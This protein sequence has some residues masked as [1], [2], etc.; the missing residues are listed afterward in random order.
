MAITNSQVT[1]ST[2]ATYIVGNDPDGVTVVLLA[3]SEDVYIGDENVTI[4]N[5]FELAQSEKVT[6]TLGP[7]E[8]IYGIVGDN[9]GKIYVIGT[10]SGG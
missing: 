1:I 3:G 4:E 9:T 6:L 5:G 7:L 8:A 2:T 10:L